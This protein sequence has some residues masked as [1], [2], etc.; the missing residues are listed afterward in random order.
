MD[1][2]AKIIFQMIN[3]NLNFSNIS[4]MEKKYKMINWNL[5]Q[6]KLRPNN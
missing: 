1:D 5:V 4:N 3:Q 6:M 2:K